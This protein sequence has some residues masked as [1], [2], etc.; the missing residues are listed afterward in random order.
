MNLLLLYRCFVIWDYHIAVVTLMSSVYL[1]IVAL[2]IAV[3]VSAENHA[4]FFNLNVHLSFLVLSC[5]FNLLFTILVTTQ[6]L[7]A[8]NRI[9]ALLAP[10]TPQL[11]RR[12]S[13]LLPSTSFSTSSSSLPSLSTATSRT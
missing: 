11:L 5:T 7:M 2:A 12:S 1:A 3:M 4:I 6:L 8:R 13:S 10:R 9:K